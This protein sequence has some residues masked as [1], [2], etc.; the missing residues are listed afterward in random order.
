MI[1]LS[2]SDLTLD[3]VHKLLLLEEREG[4]S[5]E[6][7]LTLEPITETDRHNLE[8]IRMNFKRYLSAGRALKGV[9]RFLAIAPLLQLS[10]FYSPL[11]TLKV[12]ENIAPINLEGEKTKITGRF[13]LV[14]TKNLEN[15]ME[16]WLLVIE[17]KEG[18]AA[19]R[20]GLPQVLTYSYTSLESQPSVLGL[21]TNGDSYRLS[22]FKQVILPPILC[23]QN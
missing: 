6:S 15:G 13:D 20:I 8:L 23:Y 17:T 11:I 18:F 10:G 7:L 1:S 16:F 9:V 3:E 14:A 4:L 12:E 21:T 22:I 5:F 2:A 19:P